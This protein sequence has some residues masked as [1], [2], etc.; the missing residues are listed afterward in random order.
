MI[1]MGDNFLDSLVYALV[2]GKLIFLGRILIKG[3]T[4][5]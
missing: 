3:N 5:F 2:K 4:L 1:W